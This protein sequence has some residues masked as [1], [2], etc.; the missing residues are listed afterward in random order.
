MTR[1]TRYHA[2][3]YMVLALLVAAALRLPALTTVPPG[4]HYDE[5]ANGVLAGDI[6]LRGERPIFIPSYTGKEPLFFYA[7]GGLMRAL[8]PSLFAL[9][10]TAAFIG[11]LTVAATYRLGREMLAD[12]R[13]ALLAA[14][15]LAIS[16]W[17]VL[18]S[19]LGF[20]AISQPLLQALAVAALFR[21][22]RSGRWPWLWLAGL[23]I[24]LTAYTYLAARLFPV[25]LAV[26]LLPLLLDD[27]DTRPIRARQLLFVGFV[28]FLA[29][30]PLL[31]YFYFHPDAFWVRIGQIAPGAGDVGAGLNPVPTLSQSLLR[32]LGMFFLRGDPYL[33]F[34]LPGRPLFDFITGGLLLAGWLICLLRYR[35]FP[36][37]W[38]RT[39]VLLL[40]MAPLVMLLPTALAVNEIVPSNL[41]ALGLIPFVFYLPPIGLVA[42]LRDVERRFARPPLTRAVSI[43]ILFLLLVGGI[44]T[45]N[46][47]FRQWAA[48]PDLRFIT[49]GDLTAAAAYLD[50]TLAALPPDEQPVVYVAAVHY[51]HPTLAFLSANYDRL[52]WLPGSHA[53][54]FP[55][56]GPA[57]YLYPANSP[58]PEWA[59]PYL[60]AEA[61][62]EIVAAPDGQELFRVYRLSAP[63]NLPAATGP[64]DATPSNFAGLVTLD[65]LATEPATAGT[66]LPLTLRWTVTAAPPGVNYATFAHLEDAN[67]HRWSQIEQDGYPAEQWQPGESILERIDLPAPAGMPPGENGLYR[68]RLGR[69]DPATGNRLPLLDGA[70]SFAGDSLL[71]DDV[72]IRHGP[73]P[74]PQPT[75]PFPVGETAVEGLLFAGYERSPR[76]AETGEPVALALWWSATTPLPFLQ[77]RLSLVAEGGTAHTV[78]QGQPAYNTYPFHLWQTPTFVID[79]QVFAIPDD[80]PGGDYVY[81]LELLNGQGQPV[82]S[83]DLGPLTVTRTE[84]LFELP[85]FATPVGATFGEQI[86]LPGYTLTGDGG[87]Y[88]LELVW[89]AETQPTTDYTVFVHVLNADGTCC[90]WQSD[91][92]PRGGAYPTSRWRPGEVVVDAYEIVL[93]DGLAAG[94]Q[95]IEVGLYVAETGQRL[96]VI[97]GAAGQD[98]IRLGVPVVP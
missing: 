52:K 70:G 64:S 78:I 47:Y 86:A 76:A 69:F 63:P 55:A 40:L 53:L 39:A 31:A 54:V 92:M 22:L 41:R 96:K 28:A 79:R 68:L 29:A 33:R 88:A 13:I 82:Y 38:Q 20:R 46:R 95:P 93:P 34:N 49:D 19:R 2:L 36:Y 24:G 48:Q 62:P 75:P 87:T 91:A 56:G 32:S 15:L 43:T 81:R 8:G 45:Q 97:P 61:P 16:F 83:A 89:Q 9:R 77:L 85:P 10:L 57:L 30:L 74:D 3:A 90:V 25:L 60:E 11:L 7:A 51:R 26:A 23:L 5:A 6:G 67:G 44:L 58:A 59:I 21:G 80:L 73:A 14:A 35:R 17:H 4:A 27:P 71:S 50:A 65:S 18:F 84:R 1:L 37:D 94:D 98:S 42:L 66:S 72:T 12:R